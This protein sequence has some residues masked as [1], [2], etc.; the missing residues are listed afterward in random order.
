MPR[1]NDVTSKVSVVD[2]M[3]IAS[4]DTVRDSGAM[5]S[6]VVVTVV[7]GSVSVYNKLYVQLFSY[8]G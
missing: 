1:A 4:G 7:A 8:R 2:S 6:P 3:L 5:A